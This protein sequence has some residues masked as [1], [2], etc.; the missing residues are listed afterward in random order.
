MEFD[1]KG[2]W[3]RKRTRR[4][5]KLDDDTIQTGFGSR[6]PGISDSY[7]QVALD[8]IPPSMHEVFHKLINQI[9]AK[10]AGRV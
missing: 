2:R 6:H 9:S 1:S 8:A 10:H 4:E 5:V 7:L 3:S